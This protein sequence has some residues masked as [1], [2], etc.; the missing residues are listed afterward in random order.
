MHTVWAGAILTVHRA[1]P[2]RWPGN[3]TY[4]K[5]WFMD[6]AA[7]EA[8]SLEEQVSLL[9]GASFWTTVTVPSAGVPAVKVSDGP[10]GARGGGALVGGVKAACFPAG[11]SLAATWDTE[12]LE[13]VG[14]ALAE[15]AQSKGARALLA[16]TVNLHRG[17][18]NGRNFECYSEDPYL[19]A[20]LGVAYV[21]GLQSRGVSGVIKHFVGNESEFERQTISSE[22]PERA[23]RELYLVPFEAAVRAGV[24]AVMCSY[25][26]LGGSYASEHE[27]FLTTILRDEWGFDG[28]VMSDWFA[29]H[30]TAPAVNAGLDLEMPGPALFR[31][32]KLLEAVENG[33]ASR[34]AVRASA[35]R[36][37]RWFERVGAFENPDPA[38]EQAID[39]PE[40]RA[41]IRR[42]GAEGAVLLKN[43]GL[44][45]LEPDAL[46][47]VAV[48]GPNAR[49][50]QMMGGGSAQVNAHYRVSPYEGLA[51]ALGEEKLVFA[52]GCTNHKLLPLLGEHLHSPLIVEYFN[53]PDL[54]GEAVFR[55][56]N[57]TGEM[58]WLDAVGHGVERTFSARFSGTLDVTEP[59]EYSFSLVSAG[60]SRLFVGNELVVDNWDGWTPGDSYFGTGSS[61]QV[62]TLTLP[63]GTHEVRLEYGP[64]ASEGGIS[65]AAVRSGMFK[66][67]GDDAI[68]KAV[69]LAAEADV[70]IVCVGL[71][72][73][74]ETEGNDRADMDLAGRQNDLVSRVAAANPKTVVL[75]QT[76]SPVTMPWLDEVAAALQLWFP[77][78]EC[79]NAAADVLLGVVNPSGKL[80]QTFPARLEDSP[81]M[82][83]QASTY[84]GENGQV[85]YREGVFI[86]YRHFERAG[87][88]PLFPF[89]FGLSYTT[90]SYGDVTLSAYKL[91]PG[92]TLTVSVPVTNSGPRAG[93]EVVQLYV[94]DP[95]ASLERP[96]KELKGFAKVGLE[97]GETKT[98]TFSLNM[99]SLAFF[100][101]EQNAWVAE[102]GTFEVLA[103]ASA[104]DV[105]SRAAFTLSDTWAEKIPVKP[106]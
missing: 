12:L 20:W 32:E 70:A 55:S 21:A 65:F 98:V 50:A 60:F 22:I 93:Q 27:R 23:L 48:I 82:D 24:W 96:E 46:T 57:P 18:L 103:G 68:E 19:S 88:E 25:N 95:E 74:W 6:R 15:E 67:L 17:A 16:P 34:E 4:Q 14:S 75:L 11:I 26:R 62:E 38:E 44:L 84:P 42:A 5:G 10:N 80:P 66:P 87:L 79:G 58:M 3:V 47:K 77:G 54:S 76:G 1:A 2:V 100:S 91:E 45:P 9:A 51:A 40:H 59:G 39:K 94:R 41:L 71:N 49:V 86:G 97:P 35:E 29:T 7:F 53:S 104:A 101:E 36:L 89:G 102:A 105:R 43:D 30:S 85:F 37:L 61:E 31:G 69:A 81:V 83:G 63:A 64:R 13:E 90:F 78:Q 28:L 99:R 33:S 106:S 92:G 56:E 73:E 72:G 52:Q 8:L